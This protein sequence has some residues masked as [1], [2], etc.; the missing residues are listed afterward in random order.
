MGQT[1]FDFESA[2]MNAKRDAVS[3]QDQRRLGFRSFGAPYGGFFNAALPKLISLAQA[4]GVVIG[5]FASPKVCFVIISCAARLSRVSRNADRSS[6]EVMA[7]EFSE[8]NT[9]NFS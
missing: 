8:P 1:I 3:C 4:L 2:S 7:L 5:G 9:P 6:D